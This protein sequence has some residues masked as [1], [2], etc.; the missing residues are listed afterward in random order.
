V[1]DFCHDSHVCD[2]SKL[3]NK[4]RN[5]PPRVRRALNSPEHAGARPRVP[6]VVPS[7]A[8][9]IARARTYK[10]SQGFNR[11]PPLTL[12]LAGEQDN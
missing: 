6:R 1:P 9:A 5:T 8:R 2:L 11:T 10:A 3:L 12:D 7:R 4:G